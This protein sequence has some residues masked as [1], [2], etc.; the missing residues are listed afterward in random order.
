MT[1]SETIPKLFERQAEVNPD[2][3]ALTSR[4]GEITYAQLNAKA[5]ALAFEL[6][7][8]GVTQGSFVGICLPRSADVI[9]G[10]LGILKAG[11]VYVPLDPAYPDTR[12]KFMLRDTS[13]PLTVAQQGTLDRLTSLGEGTS[14][15]AM[16]SCATGSSAV[17]PHGA[18]SPDD[19]AYVMY[20]SGSTGSPKGVMV[21]HRGIIRLVRD[22]NYCQFEEDEVFLHMA[23]LSFDASTF[24]I[25]GPLLNGGTLA[26]L[27]PGWSTPED[28]RAAIREFGVTT[29][30][31]T[32]GLFHLVADH[33]PSIFAPL[34]Q[35]LAGGDVLSPDHVAKVLETLEE[36][37]LIN[38]YGPTECTTF[39]CCFSMQKGY[40]PEKTIPIGR[41]ISRTEAYILDEQGRPVA[42]GLPG[43]LCLGGDGLAAGYLHQAELTKAKFVSL[44]L[45]GNP[46]VRVYRTGDRVRQLPDGNL[47]FLG[48]LDDQVKISGHRVE[49]GEVETAIRRQPGVRQVVVLAI[50]HPPGRKQ[51]A[52][53]LVP[54]VLADFD[55][56]NLK[57]RLA[58]E[59]PQ[60]LLPATIQLRESL[61]LT[62]NGKVDRNALT[63][64]MLAPPV[65][66]R[67][68]RDASVERQLEEIWTRILAVEVGWDDSFFDLG[69]SS[70]Q[71]MELHSELTRTFPQDLRVTD[72][73][74][75]PTI[76][77][78]ANRLKSRSQPDSVLDAV[79][80][81]VARQKQA[82]R[83]R[84]RKRGGIDCE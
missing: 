1:R 19:L 44:E 8:R 68:P 59:L 67:G 33:D 29:L 5:N 83:A 81:R 10:L 13:A 69:G 66:P 21:R 15:L 63:A 22:T 55:L 43:E 75:S 4:E 74:E 23:P 7:K 2:R 54:Q 61:P 17:N 58:E 9:V 42:P 40:R 12:L 11:G 51:L 78:L 20:T 31:L 72:L 76:R 60:F 25:W 38:G 34:R 6:I 62:P 49:P 77:A 70:L 65:L 48:R 57:S 47:E 45:A 80:L 35:L 50:E 14:V 3:V 82:Q 24:E 16:E 26:I 18:S 39:A 28:I 64:E 41:P 32:A 79:Q 30:W 46:P 37:V 73:L 52:A 36:G 84:Q 71:L 56:D 53:H 27:P